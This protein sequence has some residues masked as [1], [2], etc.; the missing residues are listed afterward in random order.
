MESIIS[1]MLFLYQTLSK[2]IDMDFIILLII[3]ILV[4]S[5]GAFFSIHGRRQK[6]KGLHES[7]PE[8]LNLIDSCREEMLITT[9]LDPST[10]NDS[11]ILEHLSESH[12]KGCEIKVIFDSRANLDDV[13]NFAKLQ[14]EGVVK[15]KKHAWP[16]DMHFIVVDGKHVRLDSHPFRQ[17]EEKEAEGRVL[18]KTLELGR[19]YRHR[20]DEMWTEGTV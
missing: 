14:D 17:Y 16:L 20:F 3:S 11:R 6:D 19:K 7:H 12:K 2:G 4:G 1:V 5:F 9:D 13:P 15:T 10:F 8:F 18:F